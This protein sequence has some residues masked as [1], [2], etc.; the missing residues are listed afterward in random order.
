MARRGRPSNKSLG[1]PNAPIVRVRPKR[2]ASPIKPT[3]M[4]RRE[5][6][7]PEAKRLFAEGIAAR[8]TVG[9][10]CDLAQISRE[11]YYVWVGEDEVFRNAVQ[12]A[13]EAYRDTL[14]DEVHRRAVDG[15]EKPIIYQGRLM[16][17]PA[18][19]SNP[20]SARVPLTVN[21]KSD[22]LLMFKTK[23]EMPTKY[24]DGE[25]VNIHA[26]SLT[27]NGTQDRLKL[28]DEI[29]G[30][31]GRIARTVGAAQVPGQPDDD[32]AQDTPVSLAVLGA[33]KPASSR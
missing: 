18:D 3:L 30:K 17:R 28:L 6:R 4:E 15:I 7:K 27:L 20:R 23:A 29:D 31:L 14:E 5:K 22:L 11:T 12:Q 19:L 32:A 24:R 9:Y 16:T 10:A 1:I 2:Q 21:E 25:G 8:G 13:I 33:T 26:R